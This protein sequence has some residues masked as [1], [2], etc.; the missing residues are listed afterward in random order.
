METRTIEANF[1]AGK[2]EPSLQGRRELRRRDLRHL[3]RLRGSTQGDCRQEPRQDLCQHRH[4]R[5]ERWRHDYLGRLHRGGERLPR[6][7]GGRHVDHRHQ[8]AQHQPRQDRGR[9]RRR[10]RSG[11]ERVRLCLR[12]GRA[13]GRSG[14]RRGGEVA[15]RRVGRCRQ[16]QAGRAP[17]LRPERGCRLPGGGRG[18]HRRAAS[19]AE[20]GLYAIGVDTNQNDLE[21]GFVVAS[22]IKDVGKAIQEVYKSIVDGSTSR[23]RCCNMASPAAASIS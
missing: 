13:V 17:A 15:G 19:R 23:A 8:R 1:D 3:L 9:G 18:R 4:R 2:Y 22:D 11:G 14:N 21:P 12:A 7:R 6:R 5:G 16:G 20:R 10:C